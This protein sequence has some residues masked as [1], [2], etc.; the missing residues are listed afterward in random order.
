MS[1]VAACLKASSIAFVGTLIRG[2]H[3]RPFTNKKTGE[4]YEERFI[5]HI[6]GTDDAKVQELPLPD[7][8]TFTQWRDNFKGKFIYVP[9]SM[10]FAKTG[11][12]F[13]SLAKDEFDEYVTPIVLDSFLVD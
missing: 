9:V 7:L 5:A 1:D 6:L 8:K 3:I 13:F 12:S 2:E 11:K 4:T 10:K